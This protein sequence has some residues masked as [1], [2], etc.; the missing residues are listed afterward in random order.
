MLSVC[1]ISIDVSGDDIVISWQGLPGKRVTVYEVSGCGEALKLGTTQATSFV[2]EDA[3]LSPAAFNY[4]VTV[5]DDCGV[6]TPLGSCF[7]LNCP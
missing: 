4:R 1:D 6:E 2:H 5:V 3:V 7:P